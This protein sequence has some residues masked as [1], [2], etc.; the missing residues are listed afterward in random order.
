MSK[1]NQTTPITIVLN[2][3]RPIADWFVEHTTALKIEFEDSFD[4]K[5]QAKT[6]ADKLESAEETFKR[7]QKEDRDITEGRDNLIE[8]VKMLYHSILA[9]TKR[10]AKQ[11]GASK[12]TLKDF[13][14]G[15]PSRIRSISDAQTFLDKLKNAILL[16]KDLLSKG[17]D[18]TSGWLKEIEVLDSAFKALVQKSAK[19]N[20][21]TSTAHKLRNQARDNAISFIDDMEL[22]ALSVLTVDQKP[23]DDLQIIFSSQN[24][25]SPTSQKIQE[26]IPNE[27]DTDDTTEE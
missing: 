22:A 18:R 2:V 7:E 8:D 10:R 1:P 27:L 15:P 13:K 6:T 23:Y 19:E 4:G 24:P 14:F 12:N 21:E 26:D 20:L 17:K 9:S 25:T 11:K 3:L 16:H 5:T